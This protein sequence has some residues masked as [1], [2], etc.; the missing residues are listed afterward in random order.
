V[1]QDRPPPGPATR[2]KLRGDAGAIALFG[3][4]AALYFA[5]EILIPFAFALVLTFV[6]T[7]A[8]ALLQRL[9]AGRALSVLSTVAVSIAVAGGTGWLIANQL[10]DVANQLPLYR[11]NIHAKIEAFH[12]P[13]TGQLGQAAASVKEIERE[14][15]N[16]SAASLPLPPEGK[17]RKQPKTPAPP[18][19]VRVIESPAGG[20]AEF[21]DLGT[22][23]LA[24]LGRAGMVVIFTVFML[25]KREDLRNRLLRLAGLGQL[26][27]LT[28]ALDDASGRVSRYLLMQFLVNAGGQ[29]FLAV[30]SSAWGQ[31]RK[32]SAASSIRPFSSGEIRASFPYR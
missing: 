7:P 8:V 4:I 18:T 24:P 32:L 25:L 11:Q 3:A 31:L 6:L 23:I 17:N 20:W 9:R 16:S 30:G 5:R 27:L 28:Q 15:S 19:P 13:A 29:W 12:M 14:L 10:V 2:S 21:R 22:P 1:K 26:N